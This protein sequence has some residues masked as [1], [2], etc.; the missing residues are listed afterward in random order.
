MFGPI[1]QVAY[2]TNDIEASMHAW[3]KQ[4]GVG[5]FT[6]YRNFSMPAV[7][8][9]QETTVSLEV[10]IAYRGNMQIELIQQ[11]NDAP[12]PYR[13][14]FEKGQMGLHHLAYVTDDIERDMQ[15][16]KQAGFDIITTISAPV[17]RYAYFQD[18]AM[19]ENYFEFLEVTPDLN[20][21]WEHC[22]EEAGRW[23]GSNPVRLMDMSGV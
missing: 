22:I 4:S 15:R 21:Y 23:D 3:V 1:R 18:P 8:K 20:K 7:H 10:G 9:G 5:P 2:L 13:S 19:P 6:W 11:T 14:F 17:G 12:S 16:A